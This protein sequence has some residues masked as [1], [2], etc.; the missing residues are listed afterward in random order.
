M[1][2]YSRPATRGEMAYIFAH[3]LPSAA[4][5]SI[6]TV[7][8]IPDVSSGSAFSSEI[9]TLY[10]AGILDGYTANHYFR[11]SN[12]ITRGE[13]SAIISRLVNQSSRLQFSIY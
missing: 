12:N 11:A 5:K 9:F 8:R 7:K 2:A 3:T 4:L 10:K 6:N 1:S 13:A